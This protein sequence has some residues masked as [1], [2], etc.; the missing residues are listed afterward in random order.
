[1]V[2][3]HRA[4]V[5]LST[6]PTFCSIEPGD[7]VANMSNT[8]FDAT[9]FE[10]WNTLTAGG[11]IVVLPAVTDRTI[12]EWVALA[13]AE[14]IATMFL[15]TSLFHAVARERPDAF[16][17][18]RNLVVGGE[19]LDLAA[20]RAVL[21]E[22]PPGRLVNGYGPT[23]TTTFATYYDC[24]PD[25]LAGLERAPIGHALQETT[26]HVVDD[27]LRP[28]EPGREGEL[29]IGGPG[30]ATGYL[31][32]ADLTEERFVVEPAGGTRVYRTGDVVR[33]LPGGALELLGRRD[34]Q[35]KLR[36]FRVELE[37]IERVAVASGLVGAAFVEK[38]G[39]GAAAQL[40]GFVLPSRSAP[41]ASRLPAELSA[42]LA[43]RVPDYMVPA[44]WLTLASVPVGPTGKTDRRRLLALLD[45][46]VEIA[47]EASGEDST[48]ETV[49]DIWCDVLGVPR[50]R[51]TDNFI[52]VGG[53][54]ILALQVASRVSRRLA[55]EL[56]PAEVLLAESLSDLVARVREVARPRP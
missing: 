7:R 6:I 53:N 18:L 13:R 10:V 31:G 37:E 43:R 49:G 32:R 40:V 15:T 24:T 48:L 51:A 29:C 44:R 16:G 55:V 25:S 19:Q 41:D 14:R 20:A 22:G 26:L 2:V 4:V 42:F 1:V 23:E 28:V 30:V 34:R 3:P 35:V 54:S 45:A 38:V 17:S 33:Q 8:A 5:R 11:T 50:A 46:P 27:E 12:D 39:D 21:A 36:G 52:E 56:E 9:T 47:D